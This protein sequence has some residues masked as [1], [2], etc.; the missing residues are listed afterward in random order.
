MRGGVVVSE[1]SPRRLFARKRR[2]NAPEGA[3]TKYYRVYV[4]AE[5]DAQLQGR[6]VAAG[7]ITVP[8]LLFE[9]AMNAQIRTDAEWKSAVAELMQV[10]ADLGRMASNLNQLTR[11]ANMEGQF[12]AQVEEFR[13]SFAAL[14]PQISAACRAVAG[15]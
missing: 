6:A 13:A 10:R 8:R 5:E 7:D 12:P 2:E 4:T 15:Q 9:S 11:Y 14:V 3:R 1:L